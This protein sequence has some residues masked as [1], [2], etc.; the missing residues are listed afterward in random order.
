MQTEEEGKVIKNI[1]F[2][3]FMGKTQNISS[4]GYISVYREEFVTFEKNSSGTV[5]KGITLANPEEAIADVLIPVVKESEITVEGDIERAFPFELAKG[6]TQPYFVDI[7]IPSDFP[8]GE[9]Y[10]PYTVKTNSGVI[11]N[12]IKIKVSDI[13]LS[14][15]QKQGSYFGANTTR[16][17]AKLEE[18]AKNRIFLNAIATSDATLAENQEYLYNKYGYNNAAI[19]FW[20]GA[21]IDTGTVLT[22]A[23]TVEAITQ[24]ITKFFN[25]L[26]L[27]A[28]TFDEIYGKEYLYGDI[29]D[30]AKALHTAGAKQLVT[31]PP[32]PELMDDGLGTGQSA[33]DIWV[34][35]PKQYDDSRFAETIAEARAK[36]DEI[37]SYNCLSQDNYSPKMLLDYPLI[38]YRLQPGFINYSLDIDGFLYW[39]IDNYKAENQWHI[40]SSVETFN[41][42]GILFYP[43]ES[44]GISKSYLSSV[45][46]KALRDGFEDYE[47]CC[48]IESLN[49]T[50]VDTSAIATSFSD[51]TKD[52]QVLLEERA[53]LVN[54][55]N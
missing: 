20:S 32:I 3:D 10:L 44:A 34:M 14:S 21:D 35:L 1:T 36:G 37:W 5:P 42:D 46:A 47:L 28:Y 18:T 51:W 17:M 4:D 22:P 43:S 39:R 6:K 8:A 54:S 48:A 49:S 41:A 31:M 2:G 15:V 7:H 25:K 24:K 38:C 45:R 27:F 23:P 29:I 19:G 33:V 9:Y 53:N 11:E 50:K 52:K 13:T 12:G 26:N 55:L 40:S 30:Y 16:T